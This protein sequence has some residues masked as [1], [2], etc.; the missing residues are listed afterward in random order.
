MYDLK[1]IWDTIA[2]N[3]GR[4]T[5]LWFPKCFSP[6]RTVLMAYPDFLLSP[7][8][9]SITQNMLSF[10]SYNVE[11]YVFCYFHTSGINILWFYYLNRMA[12]VKPRT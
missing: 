11:L 4:N 9:L 8:Y 5:I 10:S 1:W 3:V 2:D 12:C 6:D 7:S